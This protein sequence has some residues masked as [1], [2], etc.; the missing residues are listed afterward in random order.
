MRQVQLR[1]RQEGQDAIVPPRSAGSDRLPI[2]RPCVMEF[3][4]RDNVLRVMTPQPAESGRT[5]PLP[6][7]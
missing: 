1:S 4:A 5:L 3:P 6:P 7:S 2:S